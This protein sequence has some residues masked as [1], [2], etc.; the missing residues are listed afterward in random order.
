MD[1]YSV[2]EGRHSVRSYT[3]KPV[4]DEKLNRILQA[5]VLAPTAA[6]RQAFKIFVIATGDKK[7][8]L[9]EI[10]A[11]DWFVEP[12]YVLLVCTV[13]DACWVRRDEKSYGDVDSA[14][15]MDHVILAAA[16]EG[17]GT[18]WI[19][20]FDAAAAREVLGLLDGLEPIAFTPLGY[21]KETAARR[22]RKSL[23]DLVIY[24]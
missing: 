24:Q 23:S 2:I 18:C 19:G 16:A 5:A 12:P 9:K 3:D 15:V 7:D 11:K 13:K 17:L 10:Y 8:R 14:I 1:F 4:E 6:N 20:A 22:G 21:E